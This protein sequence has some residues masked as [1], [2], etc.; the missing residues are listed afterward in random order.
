MF[1][2]KD[3][4]ALPSLAKAKVLSGKNGLEN[5]VRW[6]YKPEDMNF[7]KWVRGSELLIISTPVIQSK[8]FNLLKIIEKAVG[9]HM[10]GALLLVGEH[11][12]ANIPSS[13][14]S[15]SNLHK[16]PI[17]SISGEI[18]LVDIF[19]EVGHAIAY[20]D[21]MNTV[22]NDIFSSIIFGNEINIDAF[23]LECEKNGYDLTLSQRLFMIHLHS[24]Q[25]LQTVNY[26]SIYIKIEEKFKEADIPVL[27][28]RYG[29]NFV[30]CFH[31]VENTKAKLTEIYEELNL[32]LQENFLDWKLSMGIGRAY[33]K[34]KD[35][36]KS[37]LE[38]SRCIVLTE[39]LD[40]SNGIIW[41]EDIF[42]YNLLF[43]FENK[44]LIDEFV[45]HVLG[46]L[47]QYDEENN[48]N[49]LDTLKVYLWNNRSL[50]HSA[51]KLHMHKNT[52]KYRIQRME[53]L[54][55]KSFEDSQTRLEFMNA[56]LCKE[57]CR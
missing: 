48:T 11:Y 33:E 16:F 19:E 22:G 32:Y 27:L 52:V 30:G 3:L 45:R 55:G 12:I 7:A 5:R 34:L 4:L 38:A 49:F 35:L 21:Q 29:N 28:S 8:N 46:V 17:F 57:I 40:A 36:Q 42:F 23:R 47:I 2:C 6:L 39:R 43:E 50:I 41:Y 18:P 9:L 20:D 37:F 51:E 31:A 1:Q 13:V 26:E 15:Y 53:E 24:A 54:T 56:I 10:A 14:I 44:D 25:M